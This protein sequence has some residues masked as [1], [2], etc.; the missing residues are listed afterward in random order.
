MSA[1]SNCVT[2]G[3]VTQL[4]CRFAAE[5]LRIRFSGCEL[6]R[7]RTSRSRS[8]AARATAMP[9]IGTPAAAALRDACLHVAPARPPCVMRALR[10]GAGHEREVDAEL[11]REAAHRRARVRARGAGAARGVRLEVLGRGRAGARRLGRARAAR[12]RLRGGGRRG[13][14][15]SAAAS[16]AP[17]SRASRPSA[18]ARALRRLRGRLRRRSTRDQRALAHLV[19]DAD[20]QLLARRRRP[21]TGSPSSPCRSRARSATAR[22]RRA[23]RPSTEHLDHVDVVEVA[24]VGNLDLRA[25][26]IA[27]LPRRARVRLARVDPVLLDRLRAPSRAAIAPVVGQRLQRGDRDAVAVRPRRSARS[28]SR[29]S[30]RPKPSVPSTR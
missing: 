12:R 21:A 8:R 25:R 15:G 14:A 30:E 9:A 26:A 28:R 5:S 3:T 10:A 23:R 16:A 22:R 19:A 17:A 29:V 2:C 18:R 27:S 11:A 6:G 4:R 13:A 7:R 1:S 24:D 20:E